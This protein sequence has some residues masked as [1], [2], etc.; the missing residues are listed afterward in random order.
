[1]QNTSSSNGASE[2]HWSL[3]KAGVDSSF[4]P[5]TTMYFVIPGNPG[6]PLW[7]SVGHLLL[8][9]IFAD[10]SHRYS[11]TVFARNPVSQAIG[12]LK[13]RGLSLARE[14]ICHKYFEDFFCGVLGTFVPEF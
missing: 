11:D 4:R 10:P 5:A 9:V 8:V 13:E 6:D 14:H 7:P 3:G 1:M 2:N 12:F